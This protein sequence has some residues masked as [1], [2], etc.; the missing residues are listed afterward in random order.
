VNVKV[1]PLNDT[2]E[3]SLAESNNTQQVDSPAKEVILSTKGI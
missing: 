3:L 1:I 2:F